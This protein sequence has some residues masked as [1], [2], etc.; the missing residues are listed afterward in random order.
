MNLWIKAL[1]GGIILELVLL[2]LSSLLLMSSMGPFGPEGFRGN[3]SEYLQFPGCQLVEKAAIRSNL[4]TFSLMSAINIVFW[5][6]AAYV[7]LLFKGKRPQT[8]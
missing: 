2:L 4:I 1:I 3:L 8:S 6:V 7:V 5:T